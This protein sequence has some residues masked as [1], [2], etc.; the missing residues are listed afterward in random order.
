MLISLLWQHFIFLEV[1]VKKKKKRT[2]NPTLIQEQHCNMSQCSKRFLK[3][4]M[5]SVVRQNKACDPNQ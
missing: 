3:P 2:T 5:W 1:F 4:H